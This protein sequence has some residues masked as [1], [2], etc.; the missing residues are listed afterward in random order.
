MPKAN[1]LHCAC[2]ARAQ[3]IKIRNRCQHN[4]G[5]QF[6]RSHV[7]IF[8]YDNACDWLVVLSV[9]PTNGSTSAPSQGSIAAAAA[10]AMPS[11]HQIPKL[12]EIYA[13]SNANFRSCL[14]LWFLREGSIH[15]LL[16]ARGL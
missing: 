7:G 14:S 3:N 8:A 12:P 15:A 4:S 11:V 2:W 10:N 13:N 16:A 5:S 9:T 1:Q 6:F